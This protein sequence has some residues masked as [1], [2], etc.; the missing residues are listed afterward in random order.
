M[1]SFSCPIAEEV[2]EA[3][4]SYLEK[5]GRE[6]VKLISLGCLISLLCSF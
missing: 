6:R 1:Y 5:P 4:Q 3:L 2:R